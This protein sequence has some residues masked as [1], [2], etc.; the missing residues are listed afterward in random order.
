M[1]DTAALDLEGLRQWVGRSETAQDTITPRLEASFRATL[2]RPPGQP[3]VGDPATLGVHWCLAPPIVPTEALGDDGHPRRGGFLPPVPLPR[4]MWAGGELV[5]EAP[6]QV[7]DVVTRRSQIEDVVIKEGRS[8]TMCF[9][10]VRHS[11]MTQRGAALEERQDIVYRHA[12]AGRPAA[13]VN[14]AVSQPQPSCQRVWPCDPV[15]LFRY[16][17]LTFNGHR[18][19]YDYPYV[20]EVEGYPGLIVHGPL[21]ATLLMGLATEAR[22]RTPTRFAFRGVAPLIAAGPFVGKAGPTDEGL[23][24]WIEN[25]DGRTT[26]TADALW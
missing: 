6:F 20:T 19:H 2:D 3:A 16:S 10:T 12:D 11:W 1:A 9:V 25:A 13:P 15:L 7:G 22:G 24:L 26:M 4:R 21:Q 18:I 17:A 8:G 14:D 23:R 5:F